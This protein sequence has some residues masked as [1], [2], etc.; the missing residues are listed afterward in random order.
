[1][2]RDDCFQ[3]KT[4]LVKSQYYCESWQ[5][6]A[7]FNRVFPLL[8][9]QSTV[10]QVKAGTGIFLGNDGSDYVKPMC[11]RSSCLFIFQYSAKNQSRKKLSLCQP[12]VN[13]K[14]CVDY[15]NYIQVSLDDSKESL[16]K[17]DSTHFQSI[18]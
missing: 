6:A 14:K 13:K 3:R 4:N 5:L 7:T 16:F 2:T 9:Y 17:Y 18:T 15:G 8:K 10:S 1:M 12:T 11:M